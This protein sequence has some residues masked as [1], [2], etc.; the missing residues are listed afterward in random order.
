MHGALAR[1]IPQ[2]GD[3]VV[4]SACGISHIQG[5]SSYTRLHL[6]IIPRMFESVVTGVSYPVYT[7]LGV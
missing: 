4:S 5:L 2:M 6:R 7:A 3:Q 1:N